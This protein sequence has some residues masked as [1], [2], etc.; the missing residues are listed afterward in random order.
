MERLSLDRPRSDV[1]AVSDVSV[2]D[3]SPSSEAASNRRELVA[4]CL[5]LSRLFFP[6]ESST[7]LSESGGGADVLGAVASASREGFFLLFF[8]GSGAPSA[9]GANFESLRD[10]LGAGDPTL[11]SS[12]SATAFRFFLELLGVVPLADAGEAT[13]GAGEPPGAL[14]LAGLLFSEAPSASS[15]RFRFLAMIGL[16]QKHSTGKHW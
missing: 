12:T 15:A 10:V 6:F 1:S 11:T 4:R 9:E 3:S 13:A 2:A 14:P 7:A 16:I 5:P 8:F